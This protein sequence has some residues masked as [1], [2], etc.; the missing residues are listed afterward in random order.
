MIHIYYGYG[1]GKTCSAIGA[2][3]RAVGAG[4]RVCLVQ[5][6][7]DN[8]SSELNSVSFDVFSA[9]ESLPFNPDSSYIKW[10]NHAIDY[11]KSSDCDVIILDEFM[12]AVPKFVD[13]DL[14]KSL[15]NDDKEYIITGHNPVGELIELADYVTC[16]EKK[17]HP[18]DDGVPARLGIEF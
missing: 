17:K 18:F 9:P 16:F 10:V 11:I 3:V 7:K 2:G 5:F 6:L 1:K 13:L 15:L 14:A 12:D 4:K 8:K